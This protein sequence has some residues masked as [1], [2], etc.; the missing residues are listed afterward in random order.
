MRHALTHRCLFAILMA[1]TS[2]AA[3]QT[4]NSTWKATKNASADNVYHNNDRTLY[5]GCTYQSH[6]DAMGPE[7]SIWRSATC[8]RCQNM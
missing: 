5:C 1:L 7:M 6:N 4:V 2:A 3:A 8:S